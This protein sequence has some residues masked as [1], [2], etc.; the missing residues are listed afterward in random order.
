MMCLSVRNPRFSL[1]HPLSGIKAVVS[2]ISANGK[3][4]T[5]DNNTIPHSFPKRISSLLPTYTY[6]CSLNTCLQSYYLKLV[7]VDNCTCSVS[8]QLPST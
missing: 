5:V 1:S 7:I 3:D 8:Y 4:L 2:S 6:T